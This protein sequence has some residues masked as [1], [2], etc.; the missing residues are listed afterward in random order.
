MFEE[1]HISNEEIY[2]AVHDLVIASSPLTEQRVV[3]KIGRPWNRGNT[4]EQRA[5]CAAAIRDY[6]NGAAR[7]STEG[8]GVELLEAYGLRPEAAVFIPLWNAGK[9]TDG[10]RASVEMQCAAILAT[11]TPSDVMTA[12]ETADK[13]IYGGHG[14]ALVSVRAYV[15]ARVEEG[16]KRAYGVRHDWWTSVYKNGI[17]VVDEA[18]V[19]E[20]TPIPTDQGEAWEATWARKGRGFAPTV[21]KG[22]ILRVDHTLARGVSVRGA[23]MRMDSLRL[24]VGASS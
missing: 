24:H 9:D 23:K 3:K 10:V 17:A 19:L 13:S 18:I 6:W 1:Q 15:Y 2:R 5:V 21:E 14:S 22:V 4:Q 20:A 7:W 12:I 8:A 11:T 16:G